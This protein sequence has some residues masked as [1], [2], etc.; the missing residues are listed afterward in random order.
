MVTSYFI[1]SVDA[2]AC[3]TGEEHQHTLAATFP[4]DGD[5]DVPTDGLLAFRGTNLQGELRVEVTREGVVIPGTIEALGQRQIWLA[6]AALEPQ[7]VY[8]VHVWTDAIGEN[9][10]AYLTFTTGLQPAPA[11]TVPQI[12][13][14]SV[15]TYE[16]ASRSVLRNPIP[17][18]VTTAARLRSPASKSGS[19]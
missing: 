3:L 14:I 10:D 18:H 8:D 1:P 19:R 4:G 12:A 16:K 2:Q 9:V 6:E 7:T 13:E 5:T 11:V 15:G 17:G